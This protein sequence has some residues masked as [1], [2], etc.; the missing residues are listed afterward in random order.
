M[1]LTQNESVLRT[2]K[3][4]AFQVAFGAGTMVG[5]VL[6][7]DPG[8]AAGLPWGHMN[9]R[10][11]RKWTTLR[12]VMFLPGYST[13]WAIRTTCQPFLGENVNKFKDTYNPG[14]IQMSV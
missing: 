1:R 7:Y 10:T 12:E 2:G 4:S 11:L 5:Y 8:Y 14:S 9:V 6:R 3:Y 13:G